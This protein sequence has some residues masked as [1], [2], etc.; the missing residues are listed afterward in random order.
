MSDPYKVLGVSPSATEEEVKAAYRELAKKYHPDNYADNPLAD[1]AS[2][3]MKEINEAY[4]QIVK[5]RGNGRDAGQNT[6]Q[7][8]YE[9]NYQSGGYESSNFRNVRDLINSGRIAEAQSVLDSVPAGKR[10][11]EWFF[12]KGSIFYKN[13]WINEAY[14]HFQTATQM[15]PSNNEYREAL[16]RLSWQMN[17]RGTGNFGNYG[18]YNGGNPNGCNGCDLCS[19]LCLA[20]CCCQSLGGGGC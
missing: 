2:E 3:K 17:N 8:G 13:G 1:L 15:D 7:S 12:L 18:G 9:G 20:D 5:S 11:A 6:Y 16:Q 10:D 19:G 4:D 14:T